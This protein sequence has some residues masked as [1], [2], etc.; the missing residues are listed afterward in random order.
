MLAEPSQSSAPFVGLNVRRD[1]LIDILR[2]DF[3][4]F[5][6]LFLWEQDGI[7]LG[8]PDFHEF[9]MSAMTNDT[10]TRVAIALPRDHAKTTMA[11]I[12]AI[13]HFIY[14]SH[15]F[16]VFI[17]NTSKVA[18]AGIKDIADFIR[19]PLVVSVY[20]EAIFTQAEESKGNYTLIW[21]G[22]T[23]IL[24]A[25]GAGQQVRG[26]NINNQRP[27]LAV[28]DDLESAE[29]KE[30]NKF[31]YDQLKNWFYGTFLKA[32]D[33]RRNK[34]IQIGNLVA[35]KSILADH[36]NSPFWY[37]IRLASF[38]PNGKVLWPARWTIAQ[39]RA[40]L[41]E[42]A[43]EGRMQIWLAEMLNMPMETSNKL[44]S[45][46]KA[47]TAEPVS[48]EDERILIRCITVDPA[49]SKNLAHAN[50]A[51]VVVHVFIEDHWQVGEY[52][53][54]YG[55]DPYEIYD[56]IVELSLKWRVTAVGIEAEGYQ[57][58]LINICK[59]EAARDG[60]R[61]FKFLPLVTG[62]IPKSYRIITWVAMV[63]KGFYRFT[64]N[65]FQIFNQVNAYNI[66]SDK[67]NDDIID[68]CS[69]IVQMIKNYLDIMSA[70]SN[71]DLT[72][73]SFERRNAT[74]ITEHHR[75]ATA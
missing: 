10:K 36:L 51:V 6:T 14:A 49:I 24:R 27:D 4:A 28:I 45:A 18:A 15:R 53:A 22:K 60:Y 68:A 30:D 13:H 35:N 70:S 20:G 26:L 47:V 73:E 71:E 50:A 33:R 75:R 12:A 38:T 40:D 39:L 16:A 74:L 29:E 7:E 57:E 48:P 66:N 58:A 55:M 31:G 37:A 1:D 72:A 42:Y 25:L 44:L 8:V 11:K 59:V 2:Y 52:H 65:D 5:I 63:N 17:S 56:K 62:K 34:V 3:K 46:T 41:L 64:I 67:N 23:I 69:Y 61:L 43:R 21:R 9:V 54:G 32:L 19:S